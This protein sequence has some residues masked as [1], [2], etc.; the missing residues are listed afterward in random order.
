ML[1]FFFIFII[2]GSRSLGQEIDWPS[3]EVGQLYRS[4][5]EQLSRGAVDQ[6]IILFRQ[7]IQL[8]PEVTILN[9]DLAGALNIQKKYEE[10]FTAI[11]PLLTSGRADDP[12]A[13]LN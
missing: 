12:V 8:A 13:L 5:K 3:P 2:P 7:A 9:R 6:A 11:N 1:I 4:A 10:A